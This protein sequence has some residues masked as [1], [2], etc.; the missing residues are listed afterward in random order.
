MRLT[1]SYQRRVMEHNS[2]YM[3]LMRLKYCILRV[4]IALFYNI[5]VKLSIFKCELELKE[6]MMNYAQTTTDLY[7][8]D[9]K[10]LPRSFNN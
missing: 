6:F 4:H 3:W 10:F 8:A 7:F 1:L 2:Y 9:I 5:Y